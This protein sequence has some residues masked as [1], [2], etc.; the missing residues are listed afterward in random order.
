MSFFNELTDNV[1]AESKSLNQNEIDAEVKYIKKLNPKRKVMTS[2]QVETKLSTCR[3][4]RKNV[5]LKFLSFHEYLC[6]KIHP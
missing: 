1:Q 4:C 2:E 6:G 5:Q 3:F